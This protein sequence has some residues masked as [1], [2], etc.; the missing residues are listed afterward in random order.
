VTLGEAGMTLFLLGVNHRTA[1]LEDREALALPTAEV[2]DILGRFARRG[3]LGEALVLST[4]N[5][6]EF[7][8]VAEEL[9]A[10]EREVRDVVEQLRRGDLLGPGP[11]RYLLSGPAVCAHLL[12]VA[13][14]L[15][16]MILG[17]AQIL[18]QVKEAYTL[19]RRAGTAGA[20]LDRLLETALHAGKRARSETAIG[21]GHVSMSS[22]AVAAAVD[23]VGLR[24]RRV[25]FVGAGE[26]ARLAAR[27]AADHKPGTVV[28]ANR[29]IERG[30][31][32]AR[33]VGGRTVSLDG[34]AG[35][36]ADA[37]VVFS[38]TS[39]P[40]TVI[41]ANVIHRAIATRPTR[42]LLVLDLAIPRDV[43][44]A[45]AAIPGVTLRTLDTIRAA[46]DQSLSTRSAE[47]P[48]VEA[49]VVEEA[50]RF[51]HW[52][53]G[54]AATP[55]LVALREHFERIRVEEVERLWRHAS[56]DERQRAER[57]TR[58]LV[59]RLLHVPMLRLKDADAAS[60]DGQMR[61]QAARDLFALDASFDA[62]R[63]H[64]V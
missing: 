21:A 5:R 35:A 56:D 34:L 23:T 1:T 8:A 61:L 58:V 63:S 48:R 52:T 16:S 64:D 9:T 51:A 60:A 10:A 32:L 42:P 38:A 20:L 62:G 11:H 27:H 25:L 3:V 4:C 55:T 36:I 37:D 40:G 26:T 53:R 15:D 24:G 17:D 22:S 54:L 19:A 31:A 30:E 57:L 49:I 12:R 13:C 28:I 45:A 46:V 14:G 29:T 18:G 44:P 39:A 41:T 7:Y 47:V 59:N 43:E 33:E 6:T 2:L 50:E